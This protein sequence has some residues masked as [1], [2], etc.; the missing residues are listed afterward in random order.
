MERIEAII[1]SVQNELR[2][3]YSTCNSAE[4]E[5]SLDLLLCSTALFNQC[6]GLDEGR[7]FLGHAWSLQSMLD[8][9]RRSA[10]VEIVP[11][12]SSSVVSSNNRRLFEHKIENS[13][14]PTS[15]SAIIHSS[16]KRWSDQIDDLAISLALGK[17][18]SFEQIFQQL[19]SCH[20]LMQER[21]F[22]ELLQPFSQGNLA[23]CINYFERNRYELTDA[24]KNLYVALLLRLKRNEEAKQILSDAISISNV[25]LV[26][27]LLRSSVSSMLTP[28]QSHQNTYLIETRFPEYL[29]YLQNFPT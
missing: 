13:I 20:A 22:T 3:V 15:G 5:Q 24:E 18:Q 27:L 12:V 19:L 21:F 9:I 16:T 7:R 10:A 23:A 6:G 4:G 26:S 29:R 8:R 2:H 25:N 17:T 14:E 11:S 1:S 28:E